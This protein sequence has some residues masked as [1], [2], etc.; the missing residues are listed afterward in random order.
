MPV[1]RIEK[2]PRRAFLVRQASLE[3]RPCLVSSELSSCS[4]SQTAS[5]SAV[6]HLWHGVRIVSHTVGMRIGLPE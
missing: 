4:R 6:M 2:R 1:D 5:Y 3:R